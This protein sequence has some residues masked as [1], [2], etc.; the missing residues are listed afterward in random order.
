MNFEGSFRSQPH[1][2]SSRSYVTFSTVRLI[3]GTSPNERVEYYFSFLI[4]P[5]SS[6]RIISAR[7]CAR[8][9]FFDQL[10][11]TSSVLWTVTA[12]E[13]KLLIYN[14]IQIST[15]DVSLH[16]LRRTCM[17]LNQTHGKLSLNCRLFSLKCV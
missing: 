7:L 11:N 3:K 9:F 17:H 12:L 6:I 8:K 2:W 16:F 10:R 1:G 5:A 14:G 13:I 4:V 15:R